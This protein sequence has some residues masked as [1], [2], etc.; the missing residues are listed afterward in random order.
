MLSGIGTIFFDIAI[1]WHV[2]KITNSATLMGVVG[3]M[4][5]MGKVAFGIVGGTLSDIFNRKKLLLISDFSSAS[6]LFLILLIFYRDIPNML[7]YIFFWFLLL[8]LFRLYIFQLWVP[9][10]PPCLKRMTCRMFTPS[11]P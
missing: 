1:M 5:F 9:L 11:V 4:A 7:P 2:M 6:L 3:I 10:C 8:T